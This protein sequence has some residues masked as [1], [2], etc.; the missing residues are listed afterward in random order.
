MKRRTPP[1]TS[2]SRSG[3]VVTVR[4]ESI[5]EDGDVFAVPEPWEGRRV[6]RILITHIP[7]GQVVGEGS[8]A[9]AAITRVSPTLYHGQVMRLLPDEEEKSI[10]G[11]FAA[12]PGGGGMVEPVS[13]KGD[14]YAVASGETKDAKDGELV[15]ATAWG[16]FSGRA[17]SGG[18]PSGRLRARIEARLGRADAP[19]AA[20]HIAAQ[21]HHLPEAFSEGALREAEAAEPPF[22]TPD[23][24]DIRAV[25][26]VT[27]DGEDARDFDDAVYAEPDGDAGNQ[28]GFTLLVAIA[29]VAH[30]VAPGSALDKDARLRGNSVYFP[31]R[32][33]PML[34]ERL[35]NGLC[36]LTPNEDRYCLAVWMRID[37]NGA[38]LSSRFFRAL[39][40]SRA[41]LTYTQVE[42]AKDGD[43]SALPE[44][45]A[46]LVENLL[47]AYRAMKKERERRGALDIQLPEYKVRFDEAG[48]VA[49]IEPRASLESHRLIEVF[50]VTANVAAAQALLGAKAPGIYRVH[51]PPSEDRLDALRRF[52]THAG[53]ALPKG[54]VSPKQINRVLHAAEDAPDALTIHGAILRSQAQACYEAGNAGHYGL[55]LKEYTHFTSP[56]RRYADLVVHR[57][58]AAVISGEKPRPAAQPLPEIALH[59]SQTERTA[60]LAERDALDRYKAAFM[61]NRRGEAFSGIITGANEY[62]LFVTLNGNG[63]TGFVPVRSL[64]GDFFSF[65]K[66]TQTWRGQRTR[67]TYAPGDS[68]RVRVAEANAI[69]G[70]L[71]FEL[72]EE[73]AE[74]RIGARLKEKDRNNKE[75][76]VRHGKKGRNRRNG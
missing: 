21:I 27:I 73:R 39:M 66:D 13:R 7:R 40:R 62:G 20:S 75:K 38:L 45:I 23:R 64:K 30:Y 49:A 32:V 48:E 72:E 31:D 68:L 17:F 8:R 67:K 59:I 2:A 47:A 57:S 19:R 41:R 50:M 33:I 63:I 12:L 15:R 56:I 24:E 11:V 3:E 61:S 14:H 52:L 51:A 9:L 29:D 74:R 16:E 58:L 76:S 34:P 42:A 37:A 55:G 43:E 28:G 44:G 22:L 69:T 46:P 26:L 60:M 4:I 6:P 35:S 25:P 1:R 71:V 53:H 18:E 65:R 10:V 36:S 54:Y 70:N 5:T